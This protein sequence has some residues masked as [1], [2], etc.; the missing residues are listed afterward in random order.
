MPLT[1]RVVQWP[2]RASPGPVWPGDAGAGG[3][4]GLRY[5][6]RRWLVPHPPGT[7][8]APLSTWTW[9]R[10][11]YGRS[12]FKKRILTQHT[13]RARYY[14]STCPIARGK[15]KS[16]SGKHFERPRNNVQLLKLGKLKSVLWTY[17]FQY[18]KNTLFLWGASKNIIRAS[19]FH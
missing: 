3:G 13:H 15:W 19:V 9:S 18:R 8:S 2:G 4:G 1:H 5:W 14:I 10:K 16:D 6:R 7:P 17:N 11:R 12:F